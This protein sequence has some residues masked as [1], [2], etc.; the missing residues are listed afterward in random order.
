VLAAELMA[1][2]FVLDV[3]VIGRR[4]LRSGPALAGVIVVL[5]EGMHHCP[6][7]IKNDLPGA[8]RDGIVRL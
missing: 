8:G 7:R 2:V 1:L 6:F 4:V 3:V 5:A